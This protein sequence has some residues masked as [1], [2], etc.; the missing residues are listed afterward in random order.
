MLLPETLKLHD[1][2][3]FEFQYIYFLPWKNQMVE[4]IEK[5]GGKVYCLNA[6]NNFQIILKSFAIVRFVKVNNIQIVHCHLPWA[7]VVGRV[8]H[9]L[10]GVPVAYTEH[11]KQERYHVLTRWINRL[12]F[13]WQSAAIAVSGDVANSIQQNI[14]PRIPVHNILNGVNTDFFKRDREEGEK[15]KV[16]LN[17][18]VDAIVVG[19]IAV[20]RFQKRVK[21]WLEVFAAVSAKNPNVYGIIVGDGPL[22]EDIRQYRKQLGL[23]EKVIMPGLQTEVKPW[24]NTMDIFMMTSIFEGLPIALLEAM[25]M[26]CAIAT[27]DAGGIKEVIQHNES[28]VMVGVEDWKQLE[29]ELNRLLDNETWRTTLGQSARTRVVKAFGM[30][31]MVRELEELYL[32]CYQLPA[33]RLPVMGNS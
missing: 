5:S 3:R 7:G 23:E 25:S 24:F 2:S 26:E 8:V 21:E 12:T 30:D 31:R 22:K 6:S 32:N 20:F 13:N 33:D 9:K 28:G 18:P 19:T 16:Q 4:A 15:C 27:T 29:G 10:T 14:N 17:I 11:N 1:H